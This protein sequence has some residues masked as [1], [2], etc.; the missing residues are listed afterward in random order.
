MRGP[1]KMS[2]SRLEDVKAVDRGQVPK[3]MELPPWLGML[4]C[5]N[6]MHIPI[7]YTKGLFG[8]G[9]YCLSCFG[10]RDDPRHIWL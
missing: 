3:G 9:T 6:H 5:S 10:W 2:R 4:G 1:G 7:F 8:V